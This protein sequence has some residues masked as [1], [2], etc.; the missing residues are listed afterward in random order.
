MA[1]AACALTGAPPIGEPAG[2]AADRPAAAV[3]IIPWVELNTLSPAA[4]TEVVDGLLAWRSITDRAIV[5]TVPGHAGIYAELRRRAPDIRIIP[6]LKTAS[7]LATFDSVEGWERVALDVE[8]IVAATEAEEVLLENETA[9]KA[10]Q[11]GDAPIDVARLREGLGKLPREVRYIWYPGIVGHKEET[12]RRYELVC[13]AVAEL[14]DVRFTDHRFAGRRA[15][16]DQWM[17]SARQRLKP[18][19]RRPTLPILYCYGD[20]RWWQ[21]A[22]LPRALALVEDPE[23]I[24]YPGA[25]RWVEGARSV[26]R[27]LSE[28]RAARNR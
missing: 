18:L 9:I 12:Q 20:D 6:G 23:V 21:D 24:L 4:F 26:S 16:E 25:K 15:V 5:S 7:L 14:R 2:S 28:D 19:S 10:Y 13:A 8:R 3:R 27:I 1:P 22:E 11:R 17:K